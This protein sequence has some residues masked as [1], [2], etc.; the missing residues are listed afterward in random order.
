MAFHQFDQ[1]KYYTFELFAG[2]EI[3]H[4]VFTR[5]GG[6]SPAPWDALNAGLTVG[7][8][9][10]NVLENKLR[11]FKA[12]GRDY[13]SVFDSWLVHDTGVLFAEA[14]RPAEMQS[15]P[16]GDIILTDNPDVTLFMRFADCVPILLYDPA[17]RVVGLAHAGWMGTVKQ[18]GAAAVEAMVARYGSNPADIKAAI[19]PSISPEKYEVGAEVVAQVQA[20]FGADAA[21]LLPRFNGSTH[22]DLW[23]ANRLVLEQAGVEKIAVAGI[24]TASNLDDWY[25]HRAEDG[26]TGRFGALIALT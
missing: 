22:F 9:P 17:R 20:A 10:D 8:A 25:S 5:R 21:T 14:P 12:L 2:T 16:Q 6:V 3:T 23:A 24:C 19:G 7:D 4:G 1:I 18:V 13:A 11:S 26:K 15:P